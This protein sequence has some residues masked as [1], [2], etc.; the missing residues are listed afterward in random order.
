MS[1]PRNSLSLKTNKAAPPT[2]PGS[3]P[4]KMIEHFTL[5]TLHRILRF[6]EA[7]MPETERETKLPTKLVVPI[8]YYSEKNSNPHEKT[9]CSHCC[10][11]ARLCLT[12]QPHR[13]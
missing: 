7:Q 12:L 8:M 2:R 6:L 1:L 3:Y 4:L 9:D 5:R 11:V 10:S 13:L